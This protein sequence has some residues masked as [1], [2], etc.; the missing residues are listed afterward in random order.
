MRA[1]GVAVRSKPW[2]KAVRSPRRGNYGGS[3]TEW[4]GISSRVMA[5]DGD[6]C[7]R[8]GRHRTELQSGERMEAHHIRALS[9]GGSDRMSNLVAL[10][11]TC[12]G[13]EPGHSHLRTNRRRRRYPWQVG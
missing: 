3:R 4:S 10:C 9:R 7:Q 2:S 5:R 11:S 13:R 6:R 1:A 12:H 8:C